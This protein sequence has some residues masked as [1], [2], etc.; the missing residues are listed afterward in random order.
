MNN[1]SKTLIRQRRYPDW[2]CHVCGLKYCKAAAGKGTTY[3]IDDCQCCG[4]E[5]VPCTEPRDYSGFIQ[6]PLPKD[7]DPKPLPLEVSDLIETVIKHFDFGQVHAAMTT[8]KWQWR[9]GQ[10]PNKVPT[11][12]QLQNKARDLLKQLI[13]GEDISV[14][15]SGGLYAHKYTNNDDPSDDGLKLQFVLE[16]SEAYLGDFS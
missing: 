6:W 12:S 15:G 9:D 3:H 7:I 10:G 11:I 13:N 5:E 8:L 2:I 14:I 16:T 1:N 4:D